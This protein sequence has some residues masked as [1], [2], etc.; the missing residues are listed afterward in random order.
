MAENVNID[1]LLDA[2]LNDLADLPEFG[3][4]PAGTHRVI[5]KWESKEI[6]K[7]PALE[8]KMKAVET[9]ELANPASDQPLSAGAESNVAFMLDNEIGQGKLKTAMKELAA[10][11]GGSSVRE[12]RDASDGMEI[13]VVTKTRADK[14]DPSRVYMD[15]VK[16]IS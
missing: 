3:I 16:I 2:S 14:K 8:L 1:D 13:T 7:H 5:I 12:I 10:Q 9:I 4:F 11:F 6:N 15:L